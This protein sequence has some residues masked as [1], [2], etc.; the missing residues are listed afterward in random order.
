MISLNLWLFQE[1]Y[2]SIL[3]LSL[4]LIFFYFE[5]ILN[6]RKILIEILVFFWGTIR[7]TYFNF[8]LNKWITLSSDIVKILYIK[9][10]KIKYNLNTKLIL[11]IE[12]NIW[13]QLNIFNQREPQLEII[14]LALGAPLWDPSFSRLATS[15]YPSTTSPKTTCFP[16]SHGQGMNVMKNWLPLVLGPALAME[17][18]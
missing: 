18:R 13:F 2:R 16:S 15:Y 10:R 1:R 8:K 7:N 12:K 11:W 9:F 4:S 6:T 3:N 17:S 14:M 5:V